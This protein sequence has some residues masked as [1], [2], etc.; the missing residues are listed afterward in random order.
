M[1]VELIDYKLWFEDIEST[2]RKFNCS[3]PEINNYLIE[4]LG[5]T[6]YDDI[7]NLNNN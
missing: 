4:K 6:P 5:V 2:A 1:T 3:V 7:Y